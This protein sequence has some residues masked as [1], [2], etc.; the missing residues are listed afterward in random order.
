M[1]ENNGKKALYAPCDTI[2]F[3]NY[4]NF[5]NLDL[6]INE[7][8]LFS[9]IPSEISFDA[10]MKRLKEIKSKKTILIHIEEVEINVWGNEHLQ[11]MKKQYSNINFDFAFDGMELKLMPYGQV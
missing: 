10:L 8:G 1:I 7:C 9:N 5:R 2:S 3:D 6:L 4:K 11:K